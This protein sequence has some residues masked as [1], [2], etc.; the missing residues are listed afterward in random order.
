MTIGL[1]VGVAGAYLLVVFMRR[2]RLPGQGLY[3]LR[4]LAAAG[5]IYGPP[6]SLTAPASSPC[7]SPGLL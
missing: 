4:A 1:G 7:S 6:P 5:I 3:P 2:V